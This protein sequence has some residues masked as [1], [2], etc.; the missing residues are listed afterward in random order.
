MTTT[1]WIYWGAMSV[2]LALIVHLGLVLFQPLA[3]TKRRLGDFEAL[4]PVNK[5]FMVPGISPSSTVLRHASPD[6]SY[7][8]CR[9]DIADQPIRITAK[10]P[11]SYWSIAMYS[12]KSD[13]FYVINNRQVGQSDLTLLLARIDPDAATAGEIIDVPEH[14]ILVSAPSSSG[15]VVFRAALP[16]RSSE[17]QVRAFLKS[18]KCEPA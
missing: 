1:R 18:S 8:V 9:F 10:L 6:I 2:I 15:L 7:A 17:A 13:N 16:D 4:G 11:D 14:T 12:E 3:D 5:V